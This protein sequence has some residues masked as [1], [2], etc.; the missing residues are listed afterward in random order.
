VGGAGAA[1][2][3]PRLWSTLMP[4]SWP[5]GI[6]SEIRASMAAGLSEVV[7]PATRDALLQKADSLLPAGEGGSAPTGYVGRATGARD[8]YRYV[9]DLRRLNDAVRRYNGLTQ[10]DSADVRELGP[11]LEYA[12]GRDV[13]DLSARDAHFYSG[14]LRAATAPRIGPEEGART[15]IAAMLADTLVRRTYDDLGRKLDRLGDHSRALGGVRFA[16]AGSLDDFRTLNQDIN[17]VQGFFADSETFW[18]DGEAPLDPALD[19]LLDSIGRTPLLDGP[20]FRR[21][22]TRRFRDAR[23]EK[24]REM[25]TGVESS[26]GGGMSLY[27]GFPAAGDTAEDARGALVL[28]DALR[29]LQKQSFS[30]PESAVSLRAAPPPGMT[31]TWDPAYLDRA[32]LF[33]ADY[34]RFLQGALRDLPVGSQGFIRGLA[35]V[36]LEAKMTRTIAQG[37]RY[38]PAAPTFGQRNAARELRERIAVARPAAERAV[39]LLGVFRQTGLRGPYE[40]LAATL[41][42]QD[43]ALLR[44]TDRLLE[45]SGLYAPRGG[46]FAWWS[47]SRPVAP[48]AFG[49]EDAEGVEE[50]LAAQRGQVRGLLDAFAAPVLADLQAE[51]LREYVASGDAAEHL[52]PTLVEKWRAIGAQLDAYEAKT[53][54]NSLAALEQFVRDEMNAAEPGSCAAG[55]RTARAGDYFLQARERLRALLQA[56]CAELG[57]TV[58][59]S[60]YARLQEQ[61][62][63]SLAGRFPFAARDA[64]VGDASAAAVRDFFRTW[65]ETV[66]ARRAVA[67]G[68]GSPAAEWLAQMERVRAFL[69][70]LL[71]DGGAAPGYAVAA[72]FRANRARE[73]GG[74]QVAAWS[75]DLGGFRLTPWDSAGS[76][77]PWE[78]G[79]PARLALR[80]ASESEVRPTPGAITRGGRVQDRTVTWAYGGEWGLLR[81]LRRSAAAPADLA[82]PAARARYTLRLDVPTLRNVPGADTL[83]GPPARVFVRLRLLHPETRE[84]Y[85]VPDFP[86]HA[87]F[88]R[89]SRGDA[90]AGGRTR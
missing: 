46:D 15:R 45:S 11:L 82:V 3:P 68:G 26:G 81:L 53:P 10:R 62:Q 85:T 35:A 7:F 36:Q 56:R 9:A 29:T 89:A 75:L 61:F 80:W 58:A 54:G 47:G 38:T 34:D 14:A 60:G 67:G 84:E 87:P 50:Y 30:G 79:A 17:D 83:A 90:P 16:S 57:R 8:V 71:A 42:A 88:L 52:S 66:A 44:E 48:A 21:E 72:E 43:E 27:A 20:A 24:L 59:T 86:S 65:D 40:E 63:R 70:P 74:D 13:P 6:R 73:A 5:G 1:G 25:R 39:R 69:A 32:L 41:L 37:L 4:T 33:Y 55:G 31:A 12:F 77:V 64:E 28:R 2:R 18:L 51:P 23:V 76:T 22:F 49:A 19:A 78:P